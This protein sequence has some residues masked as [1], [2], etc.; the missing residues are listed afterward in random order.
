MKTLVLPLA[1]LLVSAT[2]ALA[3]WIYE[4][5]V[6]VPTYYADQ[7]SDVRAET[8]YDQAKLAAHWKRFGLGEGRRSSP[9]FDARYY[10]QHNPDVASSVGQSNYPQA[11]L[12]WYRNGRQEGRP[13][14]PDFQVKRY[15]ELNQDVAR[16]YG[17][18][19][20]LKA[21]EHYLQ[22]GYQEGRRGK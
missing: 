12:H 16:Q 2:P 17:A 8:G 9:V 22:T 19:N 20:Y 4:P 6:F 1:I 10:L 5:A 7:N 18:Q 11:A 21:I 3:D 13:S 15:L 14:H